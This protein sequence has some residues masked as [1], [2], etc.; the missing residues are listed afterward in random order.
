VETEDTEA[1]ARTEAK[2]KDALK[3]AVA[4]KDAAVEAAKEGN[5]TKVDNAIKAAEDAAKEAVEIVDEAKK[6]GL[7]TSVVSQT[8]NDANEAAEET[9]KVKAKMLAEGPVKQA[10]EE[11][12]AALKEAEGLANQAANSSK[13]AF[14]ERTLEKTKDAEKKVRNAAAK[15]NGLTAGFSFPELTARAENAVI[16]A[17]GAVTKAKK[18]VENAKENDPDY[19]TDLREWI[20]DNGWK[21]RRDNHSLVGILTY[22]T[23]A[24]QDD[25]A[26]AMNDN[27]AADIRNAEENIKSF[28][29]K[30]AAKK[31]YW[32]ITDLHL[33]NTQVGNTQA[34]VDIFFPY[35]PYSDN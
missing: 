12:E 32:D 1:R 35:D 19:V 4:A 3:K 8:A 18:A 15:L 7:D 21:T 22:G 25:M 14:T 34:T 13:V 2:A 6:Q 33:G 23:K 5:D 16:Q 24:L 20:K 26:M 30:I 17:T 11:A 27:N 28:K 9:K 10:V 31:F 29:R